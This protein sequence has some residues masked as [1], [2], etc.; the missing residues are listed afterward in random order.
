LLYEITNAV[1]EYE[2]ICF[3]SKVKQ[4]GS[5]CLI[6]TL[7]LLFNV[8]FKDTRILRSPYFTFLYA[9][10]MEEQGHH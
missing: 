5:F 6:V 10:A 8:S 2:D 7:S 9:Q 1:G 4:S 3:V